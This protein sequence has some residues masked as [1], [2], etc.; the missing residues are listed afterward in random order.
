METANPDDENAGSE[1]GETNYDD[2]D[3]N[4][5]EHDMEANVLAGAEEEEKDLPSMLVKKQY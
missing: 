2:D 4:D 1:Q 5:N 3:S